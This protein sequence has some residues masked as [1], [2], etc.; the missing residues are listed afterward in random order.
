MTS[1]SFH[2]PEEH[3]FQHS[4][5]GAD[6]GFPVCVEAVKFQ[7]RGDELSGHLCVSGRASSTATETQ[8]KLLTLQF[9]AQ[10]VNVIG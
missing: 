1:V 3:L 2:L 9:Q 6:H 8:Q 7:L 5:G 10:T 4:V